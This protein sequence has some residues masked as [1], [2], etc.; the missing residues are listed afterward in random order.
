M[1]RS[2]DEHRI[3]FRVDDPKLLYEFRAL[4]EH[5]QQKLIFNTIL[6]D[7]VRLL[8]S[9]KRH[10]IIGLLADGSMHLEDV[11]ETLVKHKDELKM[12][13]DE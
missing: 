1:T 2:R 8:K 3:S 10:I 6:R 13:G 4:L 5:G 9:P 7:L 12:E 11:S